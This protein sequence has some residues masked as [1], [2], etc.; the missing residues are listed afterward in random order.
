M[1]NQQISSRNYLLTFSVIHKNLSIEASAAL[2]DF[3]FCVHSRIGTADEGYRYHAC[4]SEGK[5]YQR[6]YHPEN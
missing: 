4:S 6:K 5:Y 1:N 3:F 2:T